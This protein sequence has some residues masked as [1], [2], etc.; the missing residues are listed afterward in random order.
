MKHRLLVLVV[1]LAL[2]SCDNKK[3][4]LTITGQVK[5]LKK[6]KLYLQK[7]NDT[8]IVNIDSVRLY[9]DNNF[10]FE[11]PIKQPQLMYLQL[12]RDT[13]EVAD[14]FIAFFADKGELQVNADL[15]AFMNAKIAANY[16]NQKQFGIY[17]ENIKRFGD[18][19]LDLIKVELEARKTQNEIL[20]DSVNEAYD[21]MNRRRYLYAINFAMGHPDL[22]VSPY[23]LLNH[24]DYINKKY[25]DSVYK[26][27]DRNIQK[28][29]YGQK[30][31]DL[32][33]QPTQN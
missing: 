17:S 26:N 24:A 20:L 28:S 3:P 13:V 12:Q 7:I 10:K 16:E 18:Q 30:L 25:L 1:L 31:N 4:D 33:T 32:V 9:N 29:F 11:I 14:N 19:K 6:G 22:E 2:L 15:E 5:G 23:V 27:L 21:R 8:S